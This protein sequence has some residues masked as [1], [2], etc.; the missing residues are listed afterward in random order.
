MLPY[1]CNNATQLFGSSS[2][3]LEDASIRRSNKNRQAFQNEHVG[4]CCWFYLTFLQI[5]RCTCVA[6][7]GCREHVMSLQW[8][9][10]IKTVTKFWTFISYK[11]YILLYKLCANSSQRIRAY[12]QLCNG[13]PNGS[14]EAAAW[15]LGLLDIA[16]SILHSK[17][18]FIASLS[19]PVKPETGW[20]YRTTCHR[21]IHFIRLL[22]HISFHNPFD[23][24]SISFHGQW[25]DTILVCNQD[26]STQ[27]YNSSQL[28]EFVFR[29]IS[30]NRVLKSQ[31]IESVTL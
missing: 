20:E 25:I 6:A 14:K 21:Q 5:P 11:N 1:T 27:S 9:A 17:S 7:F 26:H 12:K 29:R 23:R 24:F 4:D 19:C 15:K 13:T 28:F 31:P 2:R 10:W 3:Q 8:L 30:C 16:I 18:G 22:Q